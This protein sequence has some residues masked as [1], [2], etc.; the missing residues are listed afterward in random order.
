MNRI[1][2]VT[3]LR[4]HPDLLTASDKEI[5]RALKAAGIVSRSTYYRD[6]NVRLLVTDAQGTYMALPGMRAHPM[7]EHVRSP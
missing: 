1:I 7:R 4:E 3:Y 5:V 2:A 6:C